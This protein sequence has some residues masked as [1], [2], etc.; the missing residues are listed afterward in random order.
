MNA[1]FKRCLIHQYQVL[2]RV[3]TGGLVG[4]MRA[5]VGHYNFLR[6]QRYKK[7]VLNY[8][9]EQQESKLFEIL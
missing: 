2:Q 7:I 4:L 8:I 6:C 5:Q 3:H 1:F 9:E